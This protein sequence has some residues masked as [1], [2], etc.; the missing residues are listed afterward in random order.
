MASK[1][2]DRATRRARESAAGVA[3]VASGPVLSS[4]TR[5]LAIGDPQA[6]LATFLAILDAH[7]ALDD[8]GWLSSSFRLVSMGDHFDWGKR[9]ERAQAADD[10]LAILAWLAAHP[11]EQV[12]ILAGNHDL[13]RVG[14]LAS[15]DDATFA[16]AQ[17]LADKSYY[18]EDE[19]AK[20]QFFRDHP[21]FATDEIVARDFSVFREAQR[22]LVER[23][24]VEKRIRLAHSLDGLLF[25][26][27]GMTENE[28]A[29]LGP[30]SRSADDIA[31]A[32]ND[33]LDAA[34]ARYVREGGP[35]VVDNIHV[36]GTGERE[37]MGALYHRP[38]RGLDDEEREELA[39]PP[40][41]RRF[42]VDALPRGVVQV[43]G[44]IR[45]AKCRKLMADIADGHP[46]LDGPLRSLVLDDAGARYARGV[47]SSSLHPA[48]DQA[49]RTAG[50]IFTDN[51]MSH[52]RDRP[53]DYELLDVERRG[54]A[55]HG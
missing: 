46:A 35:L 13:A 22:R 1:A 36:P 26:H 51:G 14:E 53:R 4:S 39:R 43:I 31:R 3:R 48:P 32:L 45:D 42:P 16:R 20:A 49:A 21:G 34:V 55:A 41:R 10:G 30:R 54:P 17:V 28:L 7:G 40:P 33:A 23:L 52:L 27:A 44:H 37:G 19:A 6:P 29:H 15:V 9:E 2:V 8:E 47:M 24:L 18:D 5:T 25:V 38:S 50:I 12:M 11:P